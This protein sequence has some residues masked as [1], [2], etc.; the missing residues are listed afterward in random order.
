[1][2]RKFVICS[3]GTGQTYGPHKSNVAR[4]F[5]VLN[6][7]DRDQQVGCYH[8]GVGTIPD[9]ATQD[10]L[11][12]A[13][14]KQIPIPQRQS[15]KLDRWKGSLFGDGLVEN[16]NAMYNVLVENYAEGDQIFMFGF[17]RGAFT[18]RVLAGL[19]SRCGLLLPKH[20]DRFWEAFKLYE[21]HNEDYANVNEF[22]RCY[23]R[24]D[25]DKIEV[26]FLGIWAQ[27]NPMAI[28]RLIVCHT[29]DTT[30]SSNM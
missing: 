10:E 28:C 18:V 7:A 22:K 27:S 24:P 3:D 29:R 30:L 11:S 6:L 16:V 1:M 20:R 2:A 8:P 26:E 25:S 19:L 21:P 14:K 9:Q 23:A 4:L 17:S 13:Q 12:A 5:K 15:T